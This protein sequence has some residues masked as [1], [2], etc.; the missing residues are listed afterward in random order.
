M[1]VDLFEGQGRLLDQFA[2]VGAL[3]YRL[4]AARLGAL[5]GQAAGGDVEAAQYR[6]LQHRPDGDDVQAVEQ[7]AGELERGVVVAE[8]DCYHQRQRQADQQQAGDEV[9]D[10][11]AEE[12]RLVDDDA[13]QD[14]AHQQEAGE[15][16]E[17]PQHVL[18]QAAE[19]A[20]GDAHHQHH[21][22]HHQA[23]HAHQA[24]ELLH[25]LRLPAEM[26]LAHAAA[27]QQ[28]VGDA[29]HQHGL[30]QLEQR[31]AEDGGAGLRVLNQDHAAGEDDQRQ[32]QD[33]QEV[34]EHR[35]RGQQLV[36]AAQLVYLGVDALEL[37]AQPGAAGEQGGEHHHQRQEQ[38]RLADQAVT[39]GPGAVHHRQGVELVLQAAGDL[40]EPRQV[41]R[42]VAGDPE[43]L[44]VEGA[45]Q[46]AAGGEQLLL[47]E[48]Q[49][50]GLGQQVAQLGVEAV[51]QPQA[52]AA[53][54][55]QFAA[56]LRGGVLAGLAGEQGVD[57]LDGVDD[58][59]AALVQLEL[60]Q[61]QV[62][63]LVGQVLVRTDFGQGVLLLIED[64][65]Q[66]QAAL[67]HGDLL[68]EGLFG[69]LQ[70]VEL[71]LGLDV[72]ADQ[73]VGAVGGLEQIVAQL[74]VDVG[75]GGE[76]AAAVVVETFARQLGDGFRRLLAPLGVEGV[77]QGE[78]FRLEQGNALGQQRAAVAAQ[79]LQCRV[80]GQLLTAQLRDGA[81]RGQLALQH[82]QLFGTERQVVV[83]AALEGRADCLG[84]GLVGADLGLGALGPRLRV[85]QRI[86]RLGQLRLPVVELGQPLAEH[87]FQLGR[88]Q[89]GVA[90]AQLVGA[91]RLELRQF[92][93]GLEGLL[94]RHGQLLLEA[95][96]LGGAALDGLQVV[97][98]LLQGFL[99]G[100]LLG[101]RQLARLEGVELFLHG[102]GTG[103]GVGG[104][105]EGREDQ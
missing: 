74:Q 55:L 76:Q 92:A 6:R 33:Q 41:E 36:A 66:Q 16:D 102:S 9:Q 3:A 44:L 12:R 19:L 46:A 54:L 72:L 96:Q 35:Q 78:D 90:L 68:V 61:A 94:G 23:Q 30:G 51:E 53:Q 15:D 42:L 56:Q 84:A 14:A 88:G 60:V 95:G 38:Q 1:L 20:F 22:H 93:L 25:P 50:D 71:L 48:L 8:A 86:G 81:E 73:L 70:R 26:P 64:A 58:L 13:Q 24:V 39:D 83:L 63:D 32:R 98:G 27:G 101:L 31:L 28:A 57:V 43:H 21:R 100:L 77:L 79:V 10:S 99:Q 85:N 104:A 47:V 11:R 65:G 97:E 40:L 67:E 7:A 52:G 5:Q 45:A 103:Q 4:L 80:A 89:A 69:L 37:A 34:A 82:A 105:G 87:A 49:G 18:G 62:G 2:A 91:H 59:G 17:D 29:E 75:L